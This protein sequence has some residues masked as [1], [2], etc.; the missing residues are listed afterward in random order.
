MHDTPQTQFQRIFSLST[1]TVIAGSCAAAA[2]FLSH[3]KYFSRVQADE[4]LLQNLE[5]ALMERE[6]RAGRLESF[7]QHCPAPTI[8]PVRILTTDQPEP[9]GTND[10]IYVDVAADLE[11][12]GGYA[13][14]DLR[15]PAHCT[16]TFCFKIQ[17]PA[18][19]GAITHANLALRSLSHDLAPFQYVSAHCA[20]TNTV[21]VYARLNTSEANTTFDMIVFR[22]TD[23]TRKFSFKA[24]Q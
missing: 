6:G 15:I 21:R 1:I 20:S 7:V 3:E 4:Q 22:Q 18:S 11:P 5:C 2:A 8:V 13:V 19:F 12:G 14:Q 24:M 9:A 17:F 10:Y 23:P 16:R